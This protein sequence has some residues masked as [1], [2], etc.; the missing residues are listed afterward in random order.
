MTSITIKRACTWR[1]LPKLDTLVHSNPGILE[2]GMV[3]RYTKL[4]LTVIAGALVVLAGGRALPTASAQPV[5]CGGPENPCYVVIGY[6][7][8][9]NKYL[10]CHADAPCAK[11]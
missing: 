7:A 2:G 3:D 6:V 1:E 5:T 9:G 10:P 4:V 11:K 8:A